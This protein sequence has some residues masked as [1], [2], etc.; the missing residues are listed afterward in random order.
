MSSIS[1]NNVSFLGISQQN[2]KLE[3]DF[4][5]K[6]EQSITI[7]GLLIDLSN[8]EGIQDIFEEG[9]DFF[10]LPSSSSIT[11]SLPVR[12]NELIINGKNLGDGWVDSFEIFGDHIQVAGYT[13]SLRI[14]KDGN[15]ASS[16]LVQNESSKLS[17]SSS[18]LNADDFNYLN[19]LDEN[20]DFSLNANKSIDISHEVNCSF[21]Y[22]KSNKL[23]VSFINPLGTSVPIPSKL[24]KFS[25]DDG[26][27]AAPKKYK[28]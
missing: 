27:P 15:F 14:N 17:I 25:F 16:E 1:F 23:P 9:N 18:G 24:I 5:F 13:A 6:R 28:E 4:I 2:V 8:Q 22:K 11:G 7:S 20:F 10:N 12:I 3:T 21:G 26:D 19:S